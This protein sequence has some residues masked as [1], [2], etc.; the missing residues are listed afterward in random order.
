L[1]YRLLPALLLLL[2]LAAGIARAEP[3]DTAQGKPIDWGKI[4]PADHTYDH[5]Y[6]DTVDGKNAGYWRASLSVEED[7]LVSTYHEY[8][9]ETHGG[10]LSTYEHRVVWTETKDFK[11]VHI[12][13]ATSAGSDEV[14]KTY[15]FMDDGVELT[16]EQSGRTI[17]RKLPPIKGNFLT[18]AQSSIAIDLNLKRDADAFE[19]DTLDVSAGLTPFVTTY[20]R[21]K[22]APVDLKLADGSETKAKLWVTTYAIFPGFEM[23]HWVDASN[24]MVG[25]AYDVE[26]VT[27]ESRLADA[28]VAEMEFDP[29]ELSGLSVVVPDRPIKD[30][31]LQTKIVYELS[32][33]AGDLDIVPITTAKQSVKALG[34]GEARVTVDLDAKP[35]AA[36]KDRPTEAHLA[37]SIMIDH[38]DE[39]VRKLAKQ[40]VAKLP[41]DAS[42]VK[43]ATACKRFVTRHISGASL[44]VGDGSAS[45][46]ARTQEGDCTEC[47]V[48][49]AALLRVNG[50][51]SR[52]VSGLV[53]SEDDFVGQEHVF[54]YHQWTQAW[55]A[56]APGRQD[57]PGADDH[58]KGYWLDLDSA[59][60]RYSAGHI[61][62]GVSA[63]GDD[64]QQD[65]IDLVPLQQELTI[66]IKETSK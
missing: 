52:C 42:A 9:V 48:L 41:K 34:K 16:S 44:S 19:F 2:S 66:K 28:S 59:M 14:K 38:E 21:S 15:R 62:L 4:D 23:K 50:I 54:V 27:F 3:I 5:W 51:P 63:M 29:P 35:Q 64:D 39:V 56:T 20:T 8:S 30:V 55:I 25:L 53:Y 22:E 37:S 58:Q 32:Y 43:I 57:N 7:Q 24:V 46:A 45:E 10:E 13:V 12:V 1:K 31:D 17:K 60:W 49:L 18:A 33:Q 11:P 6:L 65:M 26:A 47:S 61:A 36:V 40:A